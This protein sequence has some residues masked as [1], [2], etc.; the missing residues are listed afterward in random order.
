MLRSRSSPCQ[1]LT[2]PPSI[3]MWWATQGSMLRWHQVPKGAATSEGSALVEERE[4]RGDLHEGHRDP[5]SSGRGRGRDRVPDGDQSRCARLSAVDVAQRPADE[6]LRGGMRAVRLGPLGERRDGSAGGLEGGL[7][8]ECLECG[9][10]GG[11]HEHDREVP[12]LVQED[13]ALHW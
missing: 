10:L 8:P 7:E 13:Q 2:I 5:A 11:A 6:H 4:E 1:R 12:R 3:A 9:V